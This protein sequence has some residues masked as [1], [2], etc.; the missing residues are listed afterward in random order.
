MNSFKCNSFSTP[1]EVNLKLCTIRFFYWHREI[2]ITHHMSIIAQYFDTK[3]N[4][5]EWLDFINK[6][7]DKYLNI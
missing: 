4:A 2:T 3:Q 6:R 1:V 5:F 7:N